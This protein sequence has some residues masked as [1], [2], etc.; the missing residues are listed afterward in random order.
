MYDF[1][2]SMNSNSVLKERI[3]WTIYLGVVFFL[4]YGSSNNFASLTGPHDSYFMN[5]ETSIPFIEVFIIPYMSSDVMFCVALLLT[6][7]RFQLRVLSLRIFTVVVLSTLIFV[8][9]PLQFSFEKP[10]IE[11]FNILFK[12]LEADLSFNQ[13]PSLHISLSIILWFSMKET[14]KNDLIKILLLIWFILIGISTLVVYQH[15]FIDLPTGIIMGLFIVYLIPSNKENKWNNSFTTP[16]SIKMGLIY[17]IVSVISVIIAFNIEEILF[18]CLF[19]YLFLSY[20][21]LSSIYSFGW[22][23]L[24]TNKNNKSNVFQLV[25]F[26]PYFIVSYLTWYYY[27]NKLSLYSKVNDNF[28]IGRQPSKEELKELKELGV[29]KV[30]NLASDQQYHLKLKN[31]INFS[32]LDMTIQSTKKLNLILEEINESLKNNEKVFLHCTLGMSRTIIVLSSYL[33]KN[34]VK[35]KDLEK[36]IDEIRKENVK[37]KYLKVNQKIFKDTYKK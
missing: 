6:Q 25:I 10:E 8:L 16:R 20:F 15:H 12:M 29:T 14:V 21:L 11:T 9:F 37:S 3:V 13:L 18:K 32:C 5:W 2:P 4:L 35:L 19:T 27:K 34:N 24:L 23:F 31:T 30:I 36:R 28:Y 22:I 17:L 1:N 26:F 7:T 33:I